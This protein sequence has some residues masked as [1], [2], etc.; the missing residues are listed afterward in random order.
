MK[1]EYNSPEA[2]I[3]FFNFSSSIRTY[4]LSSNGYETEDSE[5]QPWG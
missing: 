1:K 5:E 3:D 2:E 4:D